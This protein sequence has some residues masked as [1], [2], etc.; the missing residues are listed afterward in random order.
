MAQLGQKEHAVADRKPILTEDPRKEPLLS[1][2]T[3]TQTSRVS[4]MFGRVVRTYDLANRLMSLGQDQA[5]RRIAAELAAPTPAGLALDIATG[6]ADLALALAQR[7]HKV[8]GVDV[9]APMLPP[10]RDKIGRA[11]QSDRINVLLGDAFALPFRD[12][13][14]DCATVAFGVRNMADPIAAFR[15][16]RRVVRPEGRVVCLEIM[17][18]SRGLLGQGYRLYLTRCVPL[19]GGLVSA[20]LE[21]YRYLSASV[22]GFASPQALQGIMYQAGFSSVSYE[23]RNFGT[24]AIHVGIG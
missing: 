16:M 3:L 24:I 20:D 15:E 13:S 10:A 22:I 2:E 7:A 12:A 21:A 5:W 8:I 6:T 19:I 18:P 23:T 14:F 9:C 17:P 4:R 11:K 1:T